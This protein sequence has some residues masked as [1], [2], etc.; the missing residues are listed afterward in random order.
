MNS[1]ILVGDMPNLTL[2]CRACFILTCLWHPRP[3]T[4]TWFQLGVETELGNKMQVLS[5]PHGFGGFDGQTKM[6]GTGSTAHASVTTQLRHEN[7][8]M[9]NV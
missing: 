7:P 9:P 2:P 4:V 3:A 6:T 8:T 1:C 5:S